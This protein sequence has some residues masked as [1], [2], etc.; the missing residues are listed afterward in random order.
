MGYRPVSAATILFLCFF[1]ACKTSGSKGT[2]SSALREDTTAPAINVETRDHVPVTVAK[3]HDGI[4]ATPV[5]DES[6]PLAV[7]EEC[8]IPEEDALN[9][10]ITAAAVGF[11]SFQNPKSQGLSKRDFHPKSTACVAAKFEVLADLPDDLQ[12]GIFA[13]TYGKTANTY[14]A[15]IRYSNGAPAI[16]KDHT[17]GV[18]KDGG[19]DPRAMGIK[20]IGVN[21]TPLLDTAPS[22]AGMATQDFMLTDF[23]VFFLRNINSAIKFFPG[24]LNGTAGAG[25]DD[26]E[27]FNFVKGQKII[28]DVFNETYW[29]QGPYK[30][31]DGMAVK[32][33]VKPVVCGA[34]LLNR[35]PGGA[36]D[37]FLRQ[38]A[39]DRL[40][41]GS[42]CFD[43]F[44]QKQKD[45][46]TTPVEDSAVEWKESDAPP[47]K[48][49]RITIP[50]PQDVM[51]DTRHSFCENLSFSPWNGIAEHRP[52]G[53]INRIRMTAYSGISRKR[54]IENG[55]AVGE[56][57]GSED[58]FKVLGR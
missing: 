56:P 48:I 7:G 30:F 41:K 44:V 40:A 31:G 47:V 25:L 57:T 3:L 13:G 5:C 35:A 55:V 51:S 14:R 39:S 52:L 1:S 49:A 42:V 9:A 46:A 45:T 29:S 54:R 33:M 50:G 18:L 58:F 11:Q 36:E 20:L 17:L 10:K 34:D 43:F 37:D 28:S 15:V 2:G 26:L 21:G 6:H 12:R 32:Y 53:S 23:P 22:E 38:N 19:P 27:K 16:R 4:A 8:K 24:L